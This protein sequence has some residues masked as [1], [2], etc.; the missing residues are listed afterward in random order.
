LKFDIDNSNGGTKP[1]RIELQKMINDYKG[2][3]TVLKDFKIEIEHLQ[4]LLEAARKRL[5]RD[6][7]YWYENVYEESVF[8]KSK[9]SN[10]EDLSLL[11]PKTVLENV[12]IPNMILGY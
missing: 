11:S 10:Q 7:E 6:F 2:S 9:I 3:Y 8:T 1:V 5:T 12:I 4:H